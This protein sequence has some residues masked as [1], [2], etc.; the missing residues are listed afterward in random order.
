MVSAGGMP[1]TKEAEVGFVLII[2]AAILKRAIDAFLSRYILA[3]CLVNYKLY[4]SKV[5]RCWLQGLAASS[6]AA[7][8]MMVASAAGRPTS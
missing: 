2:F 7:R 6:C 5:G 4:S 3:L 8:A 1:T